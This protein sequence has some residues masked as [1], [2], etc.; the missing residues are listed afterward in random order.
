MTAPSINS[1]DF[2]KGCKPALSIG[3]YMSAGAASTLYPVGNVTGIEINYDATSKS[4]ES[5]CSVFEQEEYYTKVATGMKGVFHEA[6]LKKLA[7]AMGQ[8]SQ[9]TPATMWVTAA[10]Q[11][12][13]AIVAYSKGVTDG[14]STLLVGDPPAVHYYQVQLVVDDQSFKSDTNLA[15]P[16]ANIYTKRTVTIWRAMFVP[17]IKMATKRD[18][19]VQISWEMKFLYDSSVVTADKVYK[20]VD[21]MSK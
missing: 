9:T 20:I 21:F 3:G 8:D 12:N 2:L 6:D 13:P 14:T 19:H 18:D 11:L 16:G 10:N 4:I 17:K 5:D 1:L 7:I 15:T